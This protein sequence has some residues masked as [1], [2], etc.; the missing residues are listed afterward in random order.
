MCRVYNWGILEKEVGVQVISG[1]P[2][3]LEVPGPVSSGQ[4][5]QQDSDSG[6]PF[7]CCRVAAHPLR[8]GAG[9][10]GT[11]GACVPSCTLSQQPLCAQPA[12]GPQD[13]RGRVVYS[14]DVVSPVSSSGMSACEEGKTFFCLLP[15][16][17]EGQMDKRQIGE[18]NTQEEFNTRITHTRGLRT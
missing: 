6:M 5:L 9:L 7:P 2:P 16:A 10:T 11:Q 15:S 18:Q 13:R 14:S 1:E 3:R 12:R 8:R 4:H 17:W